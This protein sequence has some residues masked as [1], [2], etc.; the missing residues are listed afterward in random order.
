MPEIARSSSSAGRAGQLSLWVARLVL[1]A[2]VVLGAALVWVSFGITEPVRRAG[3]SDLDTYER[4]V[5]A[6]RAGQDYYP[7]L[8]DALLAGG[9]GTLSPL[10]WRTP[11]FLTMLSW[12]PSLQS[13]QVFLGVVTAIA[14]ASAVAFAYRRGGLLLSVACGIVMAASLV[15]IAAP[16]A[17]LS[18][19]LFAGTLIL[20]SVSTYGLGWRWLGL[21]VAVLALFVRELA[22]IYVLACVVMAVREKR[23]GEVVAWVLAIVTYAAFYLWH[24]SQVMALLGP[25]DH[26]AKVDWLQFGGLKFV[27]RT[28]TFNGLLLVAPSWAAAL[29]LVIGLAG[30]A[31]LPQAGLAVVLYLLLFLVYGRPE[32]DYWGALYAPLIALGV[33]WSPAVL[34]ELLGRALRSPE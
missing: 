34:Q 6:L 1:V 32:N 3:P 24:A 8:H 9:Y 16:R 12:F 23:W 13:A 2:L 19:E 15:A 31:R 5:A 28:A 20:I 25:A 26:A 4:V 10:N 27:V 7:A 30:L 33:V 21:G 29:V 22:V 17:E 18:F 14:W 11:L